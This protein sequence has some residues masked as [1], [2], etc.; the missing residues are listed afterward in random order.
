MGWVNDM[1]WAI[2]QSTVNQE[3]SMAL[4]STRG[5]GGRALVQPTRDTELDAKQHYI[6]VLQ[7][8]NDRNPAMDEKL[9]EKKPLNLEDTVL[10]F[11]LTI[12]PAW[13]LSVPGF[14]LVVQFS[15]N[16]RE[17]LKIPWLIRHNQFLLSGWPLS[18]F[19]FFFNKNTQMSRALLQESV[20]TYEAAN[21][22]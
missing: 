3:C 14:I 22:I 4:R 10:P 2:E 16:V 17:V 19:F 18:C 1:I 5:P 11:Q 7:T 21:F 12:W 13:S 9:I 15:W 6:L 20:Q 8:F